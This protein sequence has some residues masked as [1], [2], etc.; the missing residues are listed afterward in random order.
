MYF[1]F[2][3]SHIFYEIEGNICSS[4]LSKPAILNNKILRILQNKPCE[5]HVIKVYAMI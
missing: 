5:Y 2:V 1:A 3:H 4:H